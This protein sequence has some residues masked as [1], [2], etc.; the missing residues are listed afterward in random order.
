MLRRSISDGRH[1]RRLVQPGN[2]RQEDRHQVVARRRRRLD[3]EERGQQLRHF[4]IEHE[5][6][7][8]GVLRRLERVERVLRAAR[9]HDF[10]DERIAEARHLHVVAAL[11]FSWPPP[12]LVTDGRLAVDHT[13]MTA[14]RSRRRRRPR[15]VARER[16]DRH[17]DRDRVHVEAGERVGV[18]RVGRRHGEQVEDVQIDEERIVALAGEHLRCRSA[19]AGRPPPR[20]RRSSASSGGRCSPAASARPA[21]STVARPLPARSVD[22]RH[23]CRTGAR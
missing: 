10:V 14:L 2:A 1:V 19:A 21:P 3:A 23:A 15:A 12:R 6:Q 7:R 18:V 13:P 22:A 16:R 17:F 8:R 11:C 9:N 20:A 4:G 5:R